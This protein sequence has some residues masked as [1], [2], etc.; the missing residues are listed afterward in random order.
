MRN[1]KFQKM[2]GL[3]MMILLVFSCSSLVLATG[4]EKGSDNK[5]HYVQSNGSYVKSN[6]VTINGDKYYFDSKGDM[7]TGFYTINGDTYYFNTNRTAGRKRLLAR[8]VTWVATVR[9]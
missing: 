1:S 4:L 7:V 3:M 5:Y 6:W 2:L 9:H 8:C